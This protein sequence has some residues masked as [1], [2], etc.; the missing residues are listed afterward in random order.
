MLFTRTLTITILTLLHQCLFAQQYYLKGEVRD[1]KGSPLQN[2]AI[3]QGVT[4]FLFYSGVSGSFGITTTSLKDSCVFSLDGYDPKTVA[5]DASAYNKII[6]K[7]SPP[8]RLYKLS[9]ATA[10]LK[11]ETEKQWLTG[12]ESYSS[13]VENG[14]VDAPKYPVTGVA[15]NSDR[16]SFSSIRNYLFSK[17]KVPPE[18]VRLEEVINYFNYNNKEPSKGKTFEIEPVITNCPW[19]QNN[20]LLF[21]LVRAR[22]LSLDKLPPTHLVFLMDISSSMDAPNRL[23]LMKAAFKNLARNMRAQDSVSI[24]VYGGN[25]GIYLEPTS[26]AD[27][28]QIINAIDELQTGGST[29]GE[30]GIKTAYTVAR[31]HFIK[32]GNNRVVLATDGDFNVGLRTE[33]ELNT[34]VEQE[35]GSG[36][37]LTCLGIG[38][39]EHRDPKIKTLAETGRGNFAYIDSYA[40]AEKVL[41]KE[42]TQTLYSV[43]EDAFFHVNFNP[44]YVKKYRVIGYDNKW[45]AMKDPTAEIEGGEIGSAYSMLV[46]FE[47]EPIGKLPSVTANV[48]PATF[49]IKYKEPLSNKPSEERWQESMSFTPYAQ[50]AKPYQFASSVILFGSLLKDSKFTREKNWTDLIAMAQTSVDET[51]STQKEFLK[52]VKTAYS[53]YPKKKKRK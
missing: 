31:R 1:E 3:R 25:V 11:L 37:Y 5:V 6:L 53:I 48:Q 9:S 39:G 19:N 24:V 10:G 44:S 50:L 38:M 41:I 26:G 47:I 49:S 12:D 28:Q 32:N 13:F 4:G 29:P 2:V 36:V 30:S 20:Q 21:A 34:L 8:K 23:P 51:E 46:A 14:F 7:Q 17:T 45:G 52:L 27:K 22:K 43:A 16:S 40:D 42:F 35:R 33:R 18:S 15:L